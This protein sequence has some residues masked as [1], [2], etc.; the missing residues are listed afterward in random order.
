MSSSQARGNIACA[1]KIQIIHKEVNKEK[2]IWEGNPLWSK[3]I[4]ETRSKKMENYLMIREKGRH[5]ELG[6]FLSPNERKN[7]NNKIQN[8]LA[9]AKLFC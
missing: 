5:I 9:K 4:M 7:L 8:A 3:I 1:K 2:L 6:A